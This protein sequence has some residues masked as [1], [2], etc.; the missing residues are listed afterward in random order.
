[1]KGDRSGE[2]GFYGVG[3]KNYPLKNIKL[4]NIYL[5]Q[6]RTPYI[7]KNV[8]NVTFE[9]VELGGIKVPKSP[10]ETESKNLNS[11]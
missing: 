6:C 3:V 2:C 5:R 1:V 8:E 9:N 10:A 11:Y 4:K 7:I